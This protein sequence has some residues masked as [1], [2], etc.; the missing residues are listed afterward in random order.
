M[1]SD[2]RQLIAVAKDVH[3]LGGDKLHLYALD[4]LRGRMRV[5]EQ[6]IPSFQ[7][8]PACNIHVVCALYPQD[9]PEPG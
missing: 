8:L 5:S 9:K 3:S 6:S 7:A 2:K 4:I 1:H